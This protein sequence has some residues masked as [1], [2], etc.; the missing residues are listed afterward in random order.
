MPTPD[1]ARRAL[2]PIAK[3]NDVAARGAAVVLA[4][5]R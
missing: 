1:I 5:Q 4:G 3:G 2:E